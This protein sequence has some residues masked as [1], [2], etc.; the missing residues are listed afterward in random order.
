MSYRENLEMCF[1]SGQMSATEYASH[2]AAGE[3]AETPVRNC[4]EKLE[5][6][7]LTAQSSGSHVVTEKTDSTPGPNARIDR[8]IYQIDAV[9]NSYD[10]D[11]A[12]HVPSFMPEHM[13]KMRE[14]IRAY[15]SV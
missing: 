10:L 13:E 12:L 8:A 5:Q 3:I 15:C 14:I 4:R 6:Q 9:M 1:K 7:F 2:V 11:T